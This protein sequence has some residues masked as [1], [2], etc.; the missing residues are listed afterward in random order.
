MLTGKMNASSLNSSF[1]QSVLVNCPSTAYLGGKFNSFEEFSN[2]NLNLDSQINL[3]NIGIE[4][5]DPWRVIVVINYTIAINDSYAIWNET[6]VVRSPISISGL[7]DPTYAIINRSSELYNIR[8]TRHIINVSKI[9]VWYAVP[10]TAHSVVMNGSYFDWNGAPSYIDRLEGRKD[11]LSSRGTC[12]VEIGYCGIVSIIPYA[13]MSNYPITQ[14]QIRS[15]LDYE[16]WGEKQATNI[17]NYGYGRYNFYLL[18]GTETI[19]TQ[20]RVFPE[21]ANAGLN[22]SIIPRVIMSNVFNVTEPFIESLE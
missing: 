11:F 13:T 22:G 7:R 4:Q 21:S 8:E 19:L 9:G 1:D 6:R 16:F 12:T 5:N 14:T 17:V 15:S 2:K 3:N 18:S 10:F 20:M